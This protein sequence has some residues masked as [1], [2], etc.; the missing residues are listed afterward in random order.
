M[1]YFSNISYEVQLKPIYIKHKKTLKGAEKMEILGP[2]DARKD[3]VVSFLGFLF[4]T[5]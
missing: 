5:D 1:Y 3:I 2:W 4:G